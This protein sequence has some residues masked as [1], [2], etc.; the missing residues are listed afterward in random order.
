MRSL[1]LR[2]AAIAGACAF[3]AL[4]TLAAPAAATA[5][6]LQLN[7]APAGPTSA[8]LQPFAADAGD[9]L[10]AG[11]TQK[12]TLVFVAQPGQLAGAPSVVLNLQSAISD[13]PEAS[14]MQVSLNGRDLGSLS[15]KAGPPYTVGL[16]VPAGVIQPGYNALTIAVDQVHRVDCSIAATYEL[17]TRI[18]PHLSGIQYAVAA[19]PQDNFLS[20]LA[21]ARSDNGTTP[22]NGVLTSADSDR[23]EL[24]DA[25]QALSIAADFDRPSVSFSSTLGVGPGVD[26][27]VGSMQEVN[28]LLGG[29]TSTALHEGTTITHGPNGRVAVAVIGED[30]ADLKRQIDDLAH[31]TNETTGTAQGA[32]AV[33]AQ[34]GV[35]LDAHDRISFATLGIDDRTF[36]GRLFR[37]SAQFRLP[38]DFYPADYARASIHLDA[39]YAQGLA[40]GAQLLVKLN[41]R[42]VS[43]LALSGGRAGEIKDQILPISMQAF[44]PGLNQMSIEAALP[45]PQDAACDPAHI[46]D[47][48]GRMRIAGTSYLELPDI[49][50]VGRFPD[51]GALGA[52][53]DGRSTRPLAALVDPADT[54]SLDAMGT[55]LAKLAYASGRVIDAHIATPG[56]Y[57]P[58]APTLAVGGLDSLPPRLLDEAHIETAGVVDA[59]AIDDGAATDSPSFDQQVRQASGTLA[60]RARDIAD[61]TTAALAALGASLGVL[62]RAQAAAGAP[63]GLPPGTALLVAQSSSD[64]GMPLTVVAAPRAADLTKEVDRLAR[65]A[66]WAQLAGAGTTFDSDGQVLQV[67]P[68]RGAQ[69]Y[70]SGTL[71]LQNDR[72][73]AA[74][75]LSNNP[76]IYITVLFAFAILLG[77]ATSLA[78]MRGRRQS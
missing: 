11:E 10:F 3:G 25:I 42:T 19:I 6:A 64:A 32:A 27:I 57:D 59:T 44:R 24:L 55:V 50:K 37:Q 66:L 53:I 73:V 41:G 40:P 48:G 54:T 36:S 63:I 29:K 52:S 5:T 76:A 33:A 78:L 35:P 1:A 67:V 68:V 62:P 13:A 23:H 7:A 17:W 12:H 46:A 77:V 26:V 14:H 2:L 51:I 16:P 15:L 8:L 70:S 9:L 31:Y 60:V 58:S 4:P 65:P 18:D 34:R 38:D 39:D 75:W 61:D 20:V 47:G 30:P 43:T 69:L 45:T 49:A 74:G 22:V 56:S 21:T 71:A 72:L 28:A